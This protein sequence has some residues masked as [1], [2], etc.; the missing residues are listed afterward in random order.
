[1]RSA[2]STA[3]A[4]RR[5]DPPVR[6]AH[7]EL[8]E[9]PAEALAILSEVDSVEGRAEDAE[10][11][12]SI[13]RASFSGVWPPNWITT[14]SGCSRSHTASTDGASSGSKYRRSEVS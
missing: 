9:Q 1:M 7:A 6:A 3:A 5:G 13:A 10:P 11:A 12:A 2:M 4:P 14:P 8:V